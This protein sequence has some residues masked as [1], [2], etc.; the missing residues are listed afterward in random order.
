MFKSEENDY[1]GVL[2]PGAA[3][4][5]DSL[6]LKSPPEFPA[7][8]KVF[9]LRDF[10]QVDTFLVVR[11]IAKALRL[12]GEGFF[13]DYVPDLYCAFWIPSTL[14]VI[15]L[16]TCACLHK[17]YLALVCTCL[18]VYVVELTA[19]GLV[20]LLHLRASAP[21]PELTYPHLLSAYSYSFL[22][23]FLPI[24]LSPLLTPALTL[25]LFLI[26]SLASLLFLKKCLWLTIKASLSQRKFSALSICSFFHILITTF[27]ALFLV[28]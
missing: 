25:L 24:A 7:L 20:F 10:Y 21:C 2:A 8:E 15:L 27:L 14:N 6:T 19:P 16:F 3:E 17:S 9:R 5:D 11:R 1:Y 13:E 23:F 18:G 26:S 4:Y 28:N 12:Q 22:H